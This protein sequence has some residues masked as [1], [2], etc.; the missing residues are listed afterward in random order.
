MASIRRSSIGTMELDITKARWNFQNKCV[1]DAEHKFEMNQL[2]AA[3]ELCNKA[4]EHD[5]DF[6]PAMSLKKRIEKSREISAA[7][8]KHDV[9][10]LHVVDLPELVSSS[11]SDSTS[12][13]SSR[14]PRVTFESV[15][16][17]SSKGV[18]KNGHGEN[19]GKYTANRSTP[20]PSK[21]YLFSNPEQQQE[22]FEK[23]KQLQ[24][25]LI[26]SH[27]NLI[28]ST[29]LLEKA[30]ELCRNQ[31]DKDFECPKCRR[32]FD[33]AHLML[34]HFVN[35]HYP[36]FSNKEL[37]PFVC[38]TCQQ[39]FIKGSDLLVHATAD[40]PTCRWL[41]RFKNLIEND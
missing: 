2:D 32:S 39:R 10:T 6:Y 27:G 29:E 40:H 18:L 35:V 31:Q 19:S 34:A 20:F 21:T 22:R 30:E 7:N 13:S 26:Q 24:K 33:I 8:T 36:S 23:Q 16:P 9:P 12:P 17:K 15:T 3:M 28:S 25:L 41:P 38:K 4:L 5:A 11:D 1:E 14:R 37:K